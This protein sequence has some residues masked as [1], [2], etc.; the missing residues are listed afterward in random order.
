MGDDGEEDEGGMVTGKSSTDVIGRRQHARSGK[1]AL[2]KERQ[3]P[4]FDSSDL[5]DE[6]D[7][8]ADSQRFVSTN[9]SADY[10]S[11]HCILC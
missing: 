6:S 8:D 9:C 7:D 3:Q 11:L 5:S 4:D 1:R 10:H 2:R